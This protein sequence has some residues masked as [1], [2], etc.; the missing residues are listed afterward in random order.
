[1][2]NFDPNQIMLDTL[3]RHVTQIVIMSAV[4]GLVYAGFVFLGYLIYKAI[5]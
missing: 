2:Q 4:E 1:M 3:M 5:R